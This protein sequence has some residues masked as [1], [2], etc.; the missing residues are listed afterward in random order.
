MRGAFSDR[1]RSRL[2]RGAIANDY[3]VVRIEG[4]PA[5][6]LSF[7]IQR[8]D[9]VRQYQNIDGFWLP[10]K[11]QTLVQVRLYGKKI[12]K[13]EHRKY[14]VNAGQST[15]ARSTVRRLRSLRPTSW[16]KPA[17]SESDENDESDEG[18]E[19]LGSGLD[20][21]SESL[22]CSTA[23]RTSSRGSVSSL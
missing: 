5:K 2:C 4:H 3:S 7:W 22:S 15:N 11:D 14:V 9:F 19:Q 23:A 13:I 1:S 12:L 8:A 16:R 18:N 20:N 10:E 6:K 17:R 21:T